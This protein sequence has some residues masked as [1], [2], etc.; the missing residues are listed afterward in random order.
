MEEGI[1]VL[2]GVLLGG[3]LT[4]ASTYLLERIARGRRRKVAARQL[5]SLFL[6]GMA[7][8]KSAADDR[9]LQYIPADLDTTIDAIDQADLVESLTDDEFF[10]LSTAQALIREACGSR[11]A[12]PDAPV[13]DET[14]AS[15]RIW[16]KDVEGG[17]KVLFS[18]AF[19]R[20]TQPFPDQLLEKS[21]AL[22]H[23]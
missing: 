7:A 11:R 23:L 4:P 3:L 5:W 15:F 8:L 10:D 17:L 12:F 21:D 20:R 1:F 18:Y 6:A 9:S 22:D 13:D 14:A 16:A 2:A 19:P